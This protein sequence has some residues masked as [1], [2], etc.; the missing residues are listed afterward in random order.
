LTLTPPGW[1]I[2]TFYGAMVHYGEKAMFVSMKSASGTNVSFKVADVRQI[3]E[4]TPNP[5]NPKANPNSR[6]RITFADP[7]QYVYSSMTVEEL[8]QM[9][10][11]QLRMTQ[12]Q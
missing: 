1:G 8:T 3:I 6:S 7:N 2:G 5:E 10:N 9:L 12:D 4:V 11:R